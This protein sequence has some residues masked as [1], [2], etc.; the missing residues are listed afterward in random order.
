MTPDPA[1]AQATLYRRVLMARRADM[2]ATANAARNRTA[3][4]EAEA[5]TAHTNLT[6]L[7]AEY[8]ALGR[9]A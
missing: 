6:A 2:D 8:Q 7:E 3:Q 9:A 1:L 5:E 4:F